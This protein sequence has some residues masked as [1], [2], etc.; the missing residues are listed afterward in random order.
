MKKIDNDTLKTIKGGD[1]YVSGPIINAIVSII[2]LIQEAGYN[3]GSGFRRIS[4]NEMC[5]LK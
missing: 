2:K 5:P 4:E 1:D 3:M